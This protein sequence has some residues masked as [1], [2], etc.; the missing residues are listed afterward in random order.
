MAGLWCVNVGYGR[1]EIG[2]AIARQ[3]SQLPYYNTFLRPTAC[4]N[5]QAAA[6]LA[7]S[8]LNKVFFSSSGSEAN[9][10]LVRLVRHYHRCQGNP[11]KMVVVSRKTRTTVQ[12]WRA[13]VWG[14]DYMPAAECVADIEHIG[15]LIGMKKTME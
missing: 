8:H 9:D 15:Q 5:Y 7:P 2:E 12:P 10:T 6:E 14:M 3:S 4:V 11:N 1:R 13:E